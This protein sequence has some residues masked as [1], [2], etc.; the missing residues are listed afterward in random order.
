MKKKKTRL[1]HSFIF[2][3][4]HFCINLFFSQREKLETEGKVTLTWLEISCFE[5]HFQSGKLGL[6]R[7]TE[8]WGG[9][10]W[11]NQMPG[12]PVRVQAASRERAFRCRSGAQTPCGVLFNGRPASPL[13]WADL[14]QH[15]IFPCR[16]GEC[17]SSGTST[18]RSEVSISPE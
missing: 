8:H 2:S 9:T 7:T 13:S 18:R 15:C 5:K 17:L 12:G 6:Q 3:Q 16:L 14:R 4:Y 1:T 11:E 10:D